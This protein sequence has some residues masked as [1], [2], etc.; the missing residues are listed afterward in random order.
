MKINRKIVSILIVICISIGVVSGGA[1]Y[2]YMTS[3]KNNEYA[4]ISGIIYD[5]NT[6]IGIINEICV[7][8]HKDD[9]SSELQRYWP[10]DTTNRGYYE[11][12]GL[13]AGAYYIS[14]SRSWVKVDLENPGNNYI[15]GGWDLSEFYYFSLKAGEN[16][17]FDIELDFYS[18][19][20]WNGSIDN[21]RIQGTIRLV[22]GW[23]T[24]GE[25]NWFGDN[26]NL[27]GKNMELSVEW[28]NTILTRSD[29][30]IHICDL[31]SSEEVYLDIGHQKETLTWD[32]TQEYF[33]YLKTCEYRDW[34]VTVE[35]LPSIEIG[36]IHYSI[37]W[38]I[39]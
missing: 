39:K 12:K 27:V 16:K 4:S 21:I 23:G 8:L 29:F 28:D 25:T 34:R 14:L 17:V 26:T 10:N 7:I 35:S 18:I 37:V 32:L 13:K 19:N 15:N 9:D 36:D 2:I 33:D 31:K 3:N 22:V 30:T 5:S 1:I 6:S 24:S 38:I 20:Y 11:F